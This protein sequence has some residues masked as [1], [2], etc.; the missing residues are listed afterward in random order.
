MRVVRIGELVLDNHHRAIG[1]IPADQI[2]RVTAHRML[3]A[4]E[5]KLHPERLAEPLSVVQQPGREMLGLVPPHRARID[6]IQ[7]AQRGSSSRRPALLR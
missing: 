7:A 2:Q 5:L 3:G 6:L 1:H 4:G